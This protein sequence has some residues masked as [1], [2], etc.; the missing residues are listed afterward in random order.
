MRGGWGQVVGQEWG[1]Q[2]V[3][4]MGV[5][6]EGWLG[7]GGRSGMGWSGGRSDGGWGSGVVGVRW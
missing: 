7:S 6:D 1:G 5:G 4:V 2:G 3:G